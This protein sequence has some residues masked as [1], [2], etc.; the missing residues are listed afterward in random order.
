MNRLYK[1][2]GNLLSVDDFSYWYIE[3]YYAEVMLESARSD[4]AT[5]ADIKFWLDREDFLNSLPWGNNDKKIDGSNKGGN[6]DGE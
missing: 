2:R 3:K 6:E 5:Q 4:G 1:E